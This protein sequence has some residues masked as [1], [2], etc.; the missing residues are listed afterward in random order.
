MNWL[1]FQL[2]R[3][4]MYRD[5]TWWTRAVKEPYLLWRIYRYPRGKPMTALV[6]FL[7]RLRLAALIFCLTRE[8]IARTT[9]IGPK[10][11]G[12]WWG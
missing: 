7:I 1:L 8:E 3:L 2:Y 6:S 9:L 11:Q 10:E 12:L 4:G 5:E